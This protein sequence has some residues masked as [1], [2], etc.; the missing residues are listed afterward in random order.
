MG[1][2]ETLALAGQYVAGKLN[3]AGKTS[4]GNMIILNDTKISKY[5][6][7]VDKVQGEINF[8]KLGAY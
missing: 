7:A 8:L 2:S 1:T 3:D 5:V 4:I 6:T